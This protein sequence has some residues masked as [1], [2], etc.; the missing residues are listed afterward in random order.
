[1]PNPYI[2][3]SDAAR[4]IEYYAS[5]RMQRDAVQRLYHKD[6]Q[7]RQESQRRAEEAVYPPPPR[8]YRTQREIDDY[9]NAMVNKE[10]FRR[11]KKLAEL[12]WELYH[13]TPTRYFTEQEM[14]RHV[15]HMYNQQ[16]RKREHRE[17]EKQRLFGVTPIQKKEAQ[18]RAKFHE[19]E[20]N[21]RPSSLHIKYEDGKQLLVSELA[22]LNAAAAPSPATLERETRSQRHADPERLRL[23]AQPLRVTPKVQKETKG[24]ALMPPF[25]LFG[26]VIRRGEKRR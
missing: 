19:L 10:V 14:E 16:L 20:D 22:A 13:P 2:G 7:H 15:Q 21:W 25:C 8:I 3:N 6:M 5:P 17:R 23:L 24:N 12:E 11:Q 18:E 4:Y 9:V 1:M 26:D